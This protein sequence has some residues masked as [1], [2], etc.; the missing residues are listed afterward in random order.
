MATSL[1]APSSSVGKTNSDDG[2]EQRAATQST[3]CFG[4]RGLMF[5]ILHYQNLPVVTRWASS[6]DMSRLGRYAPTIWPLDP[7]IILLLLAKNISGVWDT[8]QRT[9][10]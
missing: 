10:I 4:M 5:G 6:G 7:E 3:I 1:N 8:L 9:K 2:Q